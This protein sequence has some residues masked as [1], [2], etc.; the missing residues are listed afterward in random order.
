M[1]SKIWKKAQI[2]YVSIVE[3]EKIIPF[4]LVNRVPL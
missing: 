4:D 3:T 1:I 2:Q